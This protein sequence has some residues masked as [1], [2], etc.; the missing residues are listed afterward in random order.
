MPRYYSKVKKESPDALYSFSVKNR[1]RIESQMAA[2]VPHSRLAVGTVSADIIEAVYAYSHHYSIPL[3]LIASK[4]Q[5]DHTSGYVMITPQFSQFSKQ[6]IQKYP[7][8]KVYIWRDHCGPGFN[9]K[10][11]LKDTYTTISSDLEHG[12]HGIHID[13]SRYGKVYKERVEETIRAARFIEEISSSTLIEIGTEENLGSNFAGPRRIQYELERFGNIQ[14]FYFYTCQTGSLVREDRQIGMFTNDAIERVRHMCDQIGVFLK[15][16]NA[17]YLNEE[18]IRQRK[19]LI[20][21]INIAPQLGVLQ[22]KL[23]LSLAVRYNIDYSEY[24]TECYQSRHWEKWVL[25]N[26]SY[27]PETLAIFAGHYNFKTKEYKRL[28]EQIEMHVNFESI[29]RNEVHTL[30]DKYV[31]NFVVTPLD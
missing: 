5:I 6:L 19:R 16:H 26:S 13:F 25:D 7:N 20:D 23:T 2:K 11:D 10:S 12:F 3:M 21:A 22:T 8:S 9:G 17:D 24:V 29:L 31:K 4:N 30:L 1:G 14:N 27:S 28:R 15:E 18:E